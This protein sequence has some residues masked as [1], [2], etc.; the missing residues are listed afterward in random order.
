[1]TRLD[2]GC[3]ESSIAVQ[4]RLSNSAYSKLEWTIDAGFSGSFGLAHVDQVARSGSI[5]R[6][7]K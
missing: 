1:M 3:P 4:L 6:A 2:A 5:Q 7:A